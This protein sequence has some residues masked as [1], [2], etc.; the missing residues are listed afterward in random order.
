M[1]RKKYF[2]KVVIF[3]IIILSNQLTALSEDFKEINSKLDKLD[4]KLQSIEESVKNLE[5][6]NDSLMD[7]I[8]NKKHFK[9]NNQL[10]SFRHFIY[11]GHRRG[12]FLN[13]KISEIISDAGDVTGFVEAEVLGF[14]EKMFINDKIFLGLDGQISFMSNEYEH[15]DIPGQKKKVNEEDIHYQHRE[16]AR[17]SLIS[18]Y[19]FDLYRNYFS[20]ELYGIAGF[21][22]IKT[23]M[24]HTVKE[25]NVD[26]T[27]GKGSEVLVKAVFGAGLNLIFNKYYIV[28]FSF[29]HVLDHNSALYIKIGVQ[30]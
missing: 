24:V 29:Q 11:Y 19:T 25:D 13:Q 28:G 7:K 22:V 21:N 3:F 23:K 1:V 26:V 14:T 15:I 17:F 2:L 9:V 8:T 16:F 10:L 27:I 5:E 4:K 30:F 18:G 6:N 12:A 20:L